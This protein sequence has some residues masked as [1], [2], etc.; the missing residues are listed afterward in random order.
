M[1][2]IQLAGFDADVIVYRIG[3][4]CESRG[5]LIDPEDVA[6]ARVDELV[7]STMEA[8]GAS[9]YIMY[10][11]GKDNFRLEFNPEYKA[12]RDPTAKPYY[13]NLIKQYLLEEYGAQI[14]DGHEADDAL[15]IMQCTSPKS[16]VICT[17]DKDL[18]MIPGW[19][20]NFTRQEL[21]LQFVEEFEGLKWFYQ[22]FL[23]GDTVDN[24]IG[25]DRWGP[26]KSRRLVDSCETEL[27]MFER[28]RELY[29]DD[30]RL[31]M[32]GRCLWIQREP[33]QLWEFP[34]GH[35]INNYNEEED[36]DGET[37]QAITFRPFV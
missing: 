37:S 7:R 10:L 9:E 6:L 17:N 18:Q 20:F 32:N 5:V 28:V 36:L 35:S 27:E 33:N 21:G 15:G 3:F 16:T 1:S 13:Y 23:I 31:L 26:V 14:C 2:N 12:N 30:E 11:T 4:S 24:I 25:V 8:T 22:Q 29:D 19:H 34:E